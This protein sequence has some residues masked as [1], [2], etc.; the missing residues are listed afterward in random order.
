LRAASL[1]HL[2]ADALGGGSA[3]GLLWPGVELELELLRRLGRMSER[4]AL[5]GQ[6][7]AALI[8]HVGVPPVPAGLQTT[9]R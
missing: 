1:R 7:V 9:S 2:T 6:G 8:S 5:A 3:A 4:A